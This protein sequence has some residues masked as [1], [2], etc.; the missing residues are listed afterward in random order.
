M[1]QR[2]SAHCIL[3]THFGL[4]VLNKEGHN[5]EMPLRG[6]DHEHSPAGA[7]LIL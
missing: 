2:R 3:Q 6:S 5:V 4:H 7:R 1:I